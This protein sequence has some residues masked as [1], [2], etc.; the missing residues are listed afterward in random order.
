MYRYT[1]GGGVVVYGLLSALNLLW[2]S[3]LIKLAARSIAQRQSQSQ[4]NSKHGAVARDV[5]V[6]ASGVASVGASQLGEFNSDH[7]KAAGGSLLENAR[8][9]QER[10]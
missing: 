8:A 7:S 2:F 3:K 1:R 5:H 4:Q 6:Q 9:L 10:Q